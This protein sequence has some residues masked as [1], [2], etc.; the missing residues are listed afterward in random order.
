MLLLSPSNDKDHL[1][2]IQAYYE[3]NRF[4]LTLNSTV[5]LISDCVSPYF[6]FSYWFWKEKENAFWLEWLCILQPILIFN[7]Q[8]TSYN[9]LLLWSN[10]ENV[11]VY[12]HYSNS[13]KQSEIPGVKRALL[14]EC[15]MRTC[16]LSTEKSVYCRPKLPSSTELS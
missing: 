16:I 6:G 9:V 10:N 12:S 8:V 14:G 2:V 1:L 13:V 5:V 4:T 11:S 3:K 7:F 15:E